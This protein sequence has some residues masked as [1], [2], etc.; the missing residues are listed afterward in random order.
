MVKIATSITPAM[1]TMAA[2]SLRF[3]PAPPRNAIAVA[4]LELRKIAVQ[5]LL[6]AMLI[7]ALHA[8][9]EDAE[10]AFHRVAVIVR[11]SKST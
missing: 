6:A 11:S 2:T 7:N 9:L 10:I 8:A 1:F 4:K 5:V 3:I